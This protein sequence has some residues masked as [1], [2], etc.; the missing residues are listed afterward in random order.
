MLAKWIRSS[1]GVMI[2]RQD[3]RRSKIGGSGDHAALSSGRVTQFVHASDPICC[4]A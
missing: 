3:L 4:V 2:L 1:G